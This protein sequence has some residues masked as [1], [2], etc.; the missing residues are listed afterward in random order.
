MSQM[1]SSKSGSM[2]ALNATVGPVSMLN[3]N[4]AA[5]VAGVFVGT[6]ALQCCQTGVAANWVTVGTPLTAPG[7]IQVTG[8]AGDLQFQLVC[9][10]YTSGTAAAYL[11]ACPT[12]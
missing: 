3:A 5:I 12:S 7:V 8:L 10:A 11:A 4:V 2:A 9:S 6:V 1:I